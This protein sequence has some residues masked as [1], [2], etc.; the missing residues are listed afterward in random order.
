MQ[1]ESENNALE[2]K[3]E[4]VF[5]PNQNIWQS[6]ELITDQHVLKVKRIELTSVVIT[7]GIDQ[8]F[9]L[10]YFRFMFGKR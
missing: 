10:G 4:F 6:G 7:M 9:I 8:S 3:H 5:I 1:G 2:S